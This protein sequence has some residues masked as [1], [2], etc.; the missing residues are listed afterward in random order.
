M[1]DPR[2]AGFTIEWQEGLRVVRDDLL[3]GGSKTRF[4]PYLIQG[5]AEV[6][7]GGPFCGGAPPALA[8]VGRMFGIPVTIFYAKRKVLH[9]NQNF[10]LQQGGK[11]F[12]VPAG[13]MAVVQKRARDYAAARG[14]LFLPLGFDTPAAADPFMEAMMRARRQIGFDPPQVWCAAGSGMLARCLGEVFASSEIHAVSVGLQSRQAKQIFPPNVRLHP[15]SLPFQKEIRAHCP[16]PSNPNYDLK[17]WDQARAL[18]APGSL[19]W[20][21][22]A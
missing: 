5:A 9:R 3:L 2:A 11:I 19:F 16:F 18:A 17:A 15:C 14:A 20:N 10:V 8:A 4:L 13:Y 7:F 21:V 12:Q 1:K 22:A 6:V